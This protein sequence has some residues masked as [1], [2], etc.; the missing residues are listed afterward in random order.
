[1]PEAK[2]S[3]RYAFTINNYTDK[4]I[5]QLQK[6]EYSY[7]IYGDEV[8]E[9]GTPHLQGYV[10]FVNA[11]SFTSLKKQLPTAHIETAFST[12]E[13]NKAY[14]SKQKVLFEDGSIKHQGARNDIEQIKDIVKT[15]G[16]MRSIIEVSTSY[17]SVRMGE[18]Y[19][20]YHEKPRTWKT[21]VTWIYGPSGTGKTKHAY[22]NYPDIYTPL[23]AKWW[24]GYDA[25]KNVLLDDF[26]T[27]YM[28]FAQLLRL[29][30]RYEFKVE[31]KG[32]S[33]QLLAENI[34][35]TCPYHP[36]DLY[37]EA[38]EENLTQLIRRINEIIEIK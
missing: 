2:R 12:P 4:D 8:G 18:V 14:C 29:L 36:N 37:R 1:M 32:G 33:R 10:E 19:L 16:G 28:P 30:D 31:T 3:R 13:Q 25:H 15:G 17:Q 35:I 6:I 34:I 20:K 26:R 22:D 24:E 9:T 21:T 27:D 11:R 5:E 38:T 23:S 7:M